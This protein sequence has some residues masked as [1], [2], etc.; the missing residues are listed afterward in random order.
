LVPASGS[1][2]SIKLFQQIGMS[3]SLADTED[4]TATCFSWMSQCG[5]N[6]CFV[7][8]CAALNDAKKYCVTPLM[9]AAQ[10]DKV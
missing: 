2:D 1:L 6:K 7:E 8:G 3:F 9:V 5:S 4:Y 10:R